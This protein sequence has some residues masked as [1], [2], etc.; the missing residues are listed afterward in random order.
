MQGESW[1]TCTTLTEFV[2][3][4]VERRS[5]LADWAEAGLPKLFRLSAIFNPETLITA[6]RQ[7]YITHRKALM[8]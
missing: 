3:D 6:I 7:V 2:E 4:M 1:P 5:F 8:N